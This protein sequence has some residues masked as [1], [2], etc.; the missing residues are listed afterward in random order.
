MQFSSWGAFTEVAHE[1]DATHRLLGGARMDFSEAEDKRSGR[2]TSGQTDKDTL[3]AGFLRWENAYA[4]TTTLFAGLGH[5]ERAADY[6]ER[7]KSPAA[8][9]MGSGSASTFLLKPEKTTQL[10]TGAIYAAGPLRASASAFYAKH[11]DFIQIQKI[12]AY[13]TDAIN[14]DATTYGLEGDLSYRFANFWQSYATLAWTHGENDSTNKPLSQIAPL[15]GRLG[16]GYDDKVWSAGAL[17]RLVQG[18]K[19]FDQS[20]GNIV[21]QDIGASTGFAIVSLN[22]G[23]R[24][25]KG[26]LISAGVDNL[27][28]QTYAEFI[29][30]S[31]A[32]IGGFTQTTRVNEPGRTLWLK[33]NIAL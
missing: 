6:W 29:S 8:T 27:F 26:T 15:E 17:L 24:P 19:R 30:R 25:K 21:G 23:W 2:S 9:A 10:D 7:S 1:L 33:A 20:Y 11:K 22:A 28:D 3:K 14:I 32:M 31:G 16:A 13:A 12:N 5:S 18:Q 4:P